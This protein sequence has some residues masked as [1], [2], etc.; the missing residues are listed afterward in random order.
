MARKAGQGKEEEESRA[1]QQEEKTP[2]REE[3]EKKP[4]CHGG[5][6]HVVEQD[7][8]HTMDL[9][10][11]RRPGVPIPAASI[12]WRT[13]SWEEG[14]QRSLTTFHFP[15][16]ENG[17]IVLGDPYER[18]VRPP[19]GVVTHKLR[20]ALCYLEW[21]HWKHGSRY[22]PEEYLWSSEELLDEYNLL[23]SSLSSDPFHSL[24][25]HDTSGQ[26]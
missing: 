16:L 17:S 9:L 18:V 20:T 7:V 26:L 11:I 3:E 25:R 10:L 8:K 24:G 6:H 1:R 19:Q 22:P 23:S 12:F 14:K 2:V 15:L 13:V 4:A 5:A 21:F